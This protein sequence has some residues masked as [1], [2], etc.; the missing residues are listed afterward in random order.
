MVYELVDDPRIGE[1]RSIA[2][3]L[4]LIRRDLS[5]DDLAGTR[6]R[7]RGRELDEVGLR[8]GANLLANVLHELLLQLGGGL[9]PGYQRHI[10]VDGG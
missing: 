6:L 10:A 5:E 4:I 7:K 8:D 2:E 9:D 1:R 3:I